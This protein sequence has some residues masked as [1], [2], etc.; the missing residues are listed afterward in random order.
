[1]I[2]P[3]DAV[4]YDGIPSPV[5]LQSATSSGTVSNE[6][7]VVD[8]YL[9]IQGGNPESPCCCPCIYRG[10]MII[11]EETVVD[12]ALRLIRN[13]SSPCPGFYPVPTN[14]GIGNHQRFH[15]PHDPE[16]SCMM[17]TVICYQATVNPKVQQGMM[18]MGLLDA[19]APGSISWMIVDEL[20]TGN[21]TFK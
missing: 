12:M 21:G 2:F 7:T 20:R 14:N 16:T 17:G 11:V 19:H 18:S 10:C 1:M 5:N 6:G 15:T 13:R 3:E 9:C 4:G 8:I